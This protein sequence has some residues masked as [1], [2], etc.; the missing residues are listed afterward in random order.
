MYIR[1]F[2]SKRKIMTEFLPTNDVLFKMIFG[3][4]RHSR[5]L[6][7]F[8]NS[9]IRS[10]HPI[11]EVEIKKT[12]LTPEN[13]AQKGVRLDILA[14]TD[15]G[16]IINIEMQKKNEKD[17]SARALFYWSKLFAGQLEVSEKYHDLR[18]TISISILDFTLFKDDERFWR[19]GY[20][21]D[22]ETHEKFTD[23]LEMHFI[24][25]NKMKQM[26]EESPITFWVEF[27]KNPYSEKVK[28][29]CEF[30]PEIKEAKEV[31]ER[32]KLDP[33]AQELMRIKEKAIRDY[34]SDLSGAK[35]EG[36][37]E[38]IELKTKESVRNMKADG[39]QNSVIAKYLNISESEVEELVKQVNY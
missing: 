15:T 37:E 29:L 22:D 25:L 34:T 7:H 19:K 14:T 23:M 38:G 27:F 18:R 36:R 26:R 4:K 5:I 32:A 12:E 28:A 30:V 8:L 6:I 33:E 17:M 13:I 35:E 2:L 31:Y 24:E 9:V 20:I 39:L 10:D 11:K 16:E 21:K 3:D 1:G